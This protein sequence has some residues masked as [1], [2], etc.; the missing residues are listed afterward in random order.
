MPRG[1]EPAYPQIDVLPPGHWKTGPPP[2]KGITVREYYIAHAMQGLLANSTI[3]AEGL[4]HWVPGAAT[5]IADAQLAENEEK[6][7][8]SPS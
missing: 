3:T 7:K 1:D 2:A 8:E 5:N 4:T 6:T